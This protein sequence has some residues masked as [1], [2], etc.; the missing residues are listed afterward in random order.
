MNEW[1]KK[2]PW[3]VWWLVGVGAHLCAMAGGL[4]VYRIFMEVLGC[5]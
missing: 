2:L 4:V 5:N 1:V 3:W